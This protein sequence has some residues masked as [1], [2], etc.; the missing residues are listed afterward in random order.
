M[1]FTSATQTIQSVLTDQGRDLFARSLLGQLSF[2]LSGFKA[3]RYGYVDGNPVWVIPPGP[4]STALGD[5]VHPIG[6]G[7]AALVAIE[8]PYPNVIAAVCRLNRNDAQYGL[9]EVGLYV[10]VIRTGTFAQY[11]YTNGA[12][13][14]LFLSKASGTAGNSVSFSLVN[15]GPSLP[16]V[17]TTV[18]S[19]VTIQLATN[20]SSVVLSTMAQI[21]AAV[22]SDISANQVLACSATGTTSTV[23]GAV[24]STFLAGGTN[25]VLP[26]TVGTDYLMALAH[27]PLISKTDKTVMVFRFVVAT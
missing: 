4:G 21:A 26:Y 23:S 13:S 18:G 15:N 19:A 3:G 5:P 24:G 8:Q 12:G 22:T 25:P 10:R 17:V 16:L 11:Q 7:V 2:Q 9:G 14:L 6:S 27:T 1:P 20:S